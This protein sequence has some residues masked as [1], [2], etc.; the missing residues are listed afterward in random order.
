MKPARKAGRLV[1]LLL[2]LQLVGLTLGF[3][4]VMPGTTPDFLEHSAPL[5]T[6]I[7]LGVF[8]LFAAGAVTAAISLAA[9]PFLR[10]QSEVPALGFLAVSIIWLAVQAVDNAHILSLLSLSQLYAEGGAPKAEVFAQLGTAARSTRRWMHYT[11]LLVIDAWFLMLYGLFYRFSLVPRLLP[12][13]GI[14][15][16]L[17]HLA[18]I[19]LPVFLG[20]PNV[21]VLAYLMPVSHLALA[22]WLLVKGVEE[23]QPSLS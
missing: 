14:L 6:R 8:I 1:G 12:G 11:E 13:F 22:G 16:V 19:T 5:A 4:F 21:L 20:Y 9:Y 3:I 17:V 15:V 10:K 2:L 23:R 7:K 18:A